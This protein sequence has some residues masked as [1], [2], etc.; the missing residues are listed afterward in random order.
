MN[1]FNK[2]MNSNKNS[3]FF[4]AYYVPVTVLSALFLPALLR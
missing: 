1:E 2:Q 3:Y 4:N